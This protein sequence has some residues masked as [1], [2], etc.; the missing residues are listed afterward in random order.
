L[1]VRQLEVLRLLSEGRSNAEMAI[2]LGVAER[3]VKAHMGALFAV[4]E[5]DSR[6]RA[7]VRARELGLIP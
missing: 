1:T 6:T 7:L 3:T 5:V 2:K 4:L